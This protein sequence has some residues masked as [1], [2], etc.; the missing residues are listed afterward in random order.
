MLCSA[1]GFAPSKA[2]GRTILPPNQAFTLKIL[3]SEPGPNALKLIWGFWN[4]SRCYVV[5]AMASALGKR[6]S[7]GALLFWQWTNN[8]FLS[9]TTCPIWTKFGMIDQ[10][11]EAMSDYALHLNR[12]LWSRWGTMNP[13]CLEKICHTLPSRMRWNYTNFYNVL[14]S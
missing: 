3:L 7:G 4:M 10:G 12:P 5:L 13:N 6:G 1:S 8:V 14:K 2:A 9:Q 11:N